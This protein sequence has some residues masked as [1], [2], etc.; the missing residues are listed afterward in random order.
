[1]LLT[2]V[3]LL[4]IA[5]LANVSGTRTLARV[6]KIGLAA[7]LIG[8]IVLGLYLL[9]FQRE[10]PFSIFFDTMGAGGDES[11]FVTFLAASLS[12]LFLFYGFEAC[13][14]V[15]EEVS[16]PTRRIPRAMILT[17]VVG[18]VSG[19]LS[20]AGYVLAAP[21]LE[22]IVAGEDVDPIPGILE[23]SLGTFGS[24]VFLVITVTA[25][26]SCVLSLQAAGSRL[27]YSFGRD[28]MLPGSRWLAHLPP[29]HAVPI[30]ALVVVT[31]VPMLICL[32]VFWRPDSLARVTAFAVCGIYISFQAVVLAALRQRLKGWR[33]AGLWNLG[34]CR[35]AGQRRSRSPTASSR[36]TCSS[37][38]GTPARSSTAGSSP[39]GVAIV[40]GSGL[41]YLLLARPDR[42]SDGV[43]EGDAIE[44]ARAP[45]ADP[46]RPT[47][48]PCPTR[49][50]APNAAVPTVRRSDEV[51]LRDAARLP[52]RGVA[53]GHQAGRRARLLRRATRPTRPGTRT[54]GCC[55]PR[56]PQ[57]TSQ[58][59]MGPSL[60]GVVLREPT[61]IAQAA[62]T[63]DELTNGRAEVVLGS[64]N[65]GL[66]AEYK[67]DW[68][69]TKPL[70]R[71]IEG[72]KVVRTLLDDG[73]ITFDGEFFRYD[74]LFTFARPVQDHLP[75]KMGA[76]R[77]PKSFEAVRRALRR[78]P[79]RP[80]LHP[81]GLRLRRRAPAGRAPR[82]PARTGRRWT[83][84]RGSSSPSA[85]TPPRPR[86]P[87]AAWSAS[88]RRRCRPSSWSATGW[89]P[90]SLKPII[91]A[92][93]GGDLAR[94]IELTTPEIA[95]K[96]S[97]AG[98]PDEVT[99]KI[100]EIEPAGVN[101][102]IAA[103]TDASLVK[104][105]T[106]QELPGVATVD[107]QLRLL[108]DEVMPAFA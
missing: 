8:V 59:R 22:S 66:L 47:A 3:G 15:A 87:P 20:Y 7:E 99:A 64:G 92:I 46:R 83:S 74:G 33:P 62:A 25:F 69:K 107:E 79:P 49:A 6:A 58:I 70:S 91:D 53:A 54:S 65:F 4:V 101:H 95:E 52:A 80:Q 12:G 97:F 26:I 17:I 51:Q 24:K 28:R 10:Q 86:P 37:A 106:G 31:V 13:G 11:Y 43:P 72:V 34:G 9:L 23:S 56:P 30:N 27:L 67:I 93:G 2:A 42:H 89:T 55:S 90:T 84:A 50:P 96:L 36:S 98:T 48:P 81:R 76:M 103:I 29:R 60:S 104:A 39:S 73:A 63:L 94:G 61:L 40:A 71:V 88:T 82:R 100:K 21:D 16:D 57:Q 78:L 85:G 77:G 35:A 68:K 44:V 1:M 18:G 45:P 41:L 108:H 105:F 32:F 14:D 5:F 102:L 75:V 38:R 19:F